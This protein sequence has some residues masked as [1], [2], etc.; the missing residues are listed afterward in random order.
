[1]NRSLPIA[2]LAGALF[3]GQTLACACSL[4]KVEIAPLAAENGDTYHGTVGDV[5][6]LFHNDVKDH[7]VTLFP[8]PPM[9][10]RSGGA[11][12]R[13][14]SARGP[15]RP[16]APGSRRRGQALAVTHK[17]R[18]S[19]ARNALR[20]RPRGRYRLRISPPAA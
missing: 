2:V 19:G 5:E 11:E 8:E 17:S 15:I 18:P 10:P 16:G 9:R 4:N 13:R 1:M 14:L 12:E 20:R 6:V 7:P 3:T